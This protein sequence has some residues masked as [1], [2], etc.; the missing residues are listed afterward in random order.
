[1]SN[2]GRILSYSGIICIAV[3]ATMSLGSSVGLTT[4]G[5]GLIMAGLWEDEGRWD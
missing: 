4:L 1:M 2:I 3:A 5:L